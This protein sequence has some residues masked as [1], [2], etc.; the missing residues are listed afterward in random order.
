VIAPLDSG[1]SG[2][3][4]SCR[5]WHRHGILS[6]ALIIASLRFI[7]SR[8]Q[9]EDRPELSSR[10]SL[11][12]RPGRR[13]GP[14]ILE[15]LGVITGGPYYDQVGLEIPQRLDGHSGRLRRV[16]ITGSG[17]GGVVSGGPGDR[18]KRPRSR[19]FSRR[20]STRRSNALRRFH[21]EGRQV[22]HRHEHPRQESR[23]TRTRAA[24]FG[25]TGGEVV[26]NS[27]IRTFARKPRC[28]WT[29]EFS[30]CATASKPWRSSIGRV[31]RNS[32]SRRSLRCRHPH[33]Q[34]RVRRRVAK[35]QK[36]PRR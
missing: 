32:R 25:M 29:R 20:R 31:I 2:L 22:L 27:I 6:L 1:T 21:G 26:L 18:L 34:P 10:C 4:T 23:A 7:L 12:A 3:A 13:G 14:R 5:L 17:E 28:P 8:V 35:A 11:H 9:D 30:A 33:P 15:T 36:G 16:R 24:H 19:S